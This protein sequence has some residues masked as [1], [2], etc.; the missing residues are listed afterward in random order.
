MTEPE[1][2]AIIAACRSVRDMCGA[3]A[4]GLEHLNTALFKL[5][6]IFQIGETS[7]VTVQ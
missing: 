6:A 2:V 7:G 3:R 5:E 4:E 1:L